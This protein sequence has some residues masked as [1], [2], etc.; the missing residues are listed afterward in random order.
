MTYRL[1]VEPVLC[2][3]LIT[4]FVRYTL[5]QSLV[6]DKTCEKL[7]GHG[8]LSTHFFIQSEIAL[9]ESEICANS[10][11]K[12]NDTDTKAIAYR[13][14]IISSTVLLIPSLVSSTIIGTSALCSHQL[15]NKCALLQCR[16]TLTDAYA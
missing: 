7:H 5:I 8:T 6:V 11:L 1:G 16:T 13:F 15:V 3:F 12:G 9:A 2:A 10:T 4:S 14:N